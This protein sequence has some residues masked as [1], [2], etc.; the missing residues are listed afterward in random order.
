MQAD[1]GAAGETVPSAQE[2]I[3]RGGFGR[4]SGATEL[5]PRSC[6]IGSLAADGRLTR[7]AADRWDPLSAFRHGGRTGRGL[8]QDLRL[9]SASREPLAHIPIAVL[10]ELFFVVE[11]KRSLDMAFPVS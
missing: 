8:D 6:F 2:E 5:S 7:R 1:G 10:A 4:M 9:L 11:G 3:A